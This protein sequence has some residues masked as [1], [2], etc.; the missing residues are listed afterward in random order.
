MNRCPHVNDPLL[1]RISGASRKARKAP[2]FRVP[3]RQR[4]NHSICGHSATRASSDVPVSPVKRGM[5][6][7]EFDGIS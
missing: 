5:R 1:W 4:D 6:S 3:P 7:H 2:V